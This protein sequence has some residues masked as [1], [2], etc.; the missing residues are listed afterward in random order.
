MDRSTPE[1]EAEFRRNQKRQEICEILAKLPT[2]EDAFVEHSSWY[3]NKKDNFVCQSVLTIFGEIGCFKW[4]VAG[5][6]PTFSDS[7]FETEEQTQRN[8][9]QFLQEHAD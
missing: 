4:V 2:T 5:G 7:E 3:R 8:L 1:G 9:W 6:K